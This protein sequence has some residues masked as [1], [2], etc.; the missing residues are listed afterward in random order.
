M[1]RALCYGSFDILTFGHI[2][3]IKRATAITNN[4]VIGIGANNNKIS[5]FSID[6]RIDMLQKAT[7]NM[8]NVEIKTFLNI[9]IE[10]AEDIG[11]KYIIRGI[12]NMHDYDYEFSIEKTDLKLNNSI[13]HIYLMSYDFTS[14]SLVRMLWEKSMT[15]P[16][17]EHEYKSMI[18]SY[19]YTALKNKQLTKEIA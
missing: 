19:V 15:E 9:P 18:P 4:L 1:D 3:L 10:F 14:S 2:D 8:S 5:L 7:K 11:V 6:E 13:E 16:G 17:Y 12:R